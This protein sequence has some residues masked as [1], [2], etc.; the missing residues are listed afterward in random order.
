MR[1]GELLDRT[2][3]VLDE[4][5]LE[6]L[7]ERDPETG[8]RLA[9]VELAKIAYASGGL[10]VAGMLARPRG[11]GPHPSVIW[12]RGGHGASGVISARQAATQLAPIADRGYVVVASQYRGN[13][14]GEG[15]DEFG[16]AELADVLNLVPL[17]D[18][19]PDADPERIGMWG[20]SRGGLMTYLAMARTERLRAAVALS[21]VS[22]LADYLAHRPEMRQRVFDKLLPTDPAEREAAIARRSPVRWP[23]KL[24]KTTPLLVMH[25]SADWRVHAGQAL[26]MAAALQ[27]AMHP[28]RFVLFEGADHGLAEF[29]GEAQR[30][31]QEWLDRYLR[32]RLPWPSLEPHGL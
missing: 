20:W 2:P 29:S 1:D 4:A 9:R 16:G 24:C 12:N 30:F 18:A 3:I 25:G 17:L 5:T 8:R 14:G 31:A 11:P 10:R 23:E 22:D 26:A 32:D 19:M 21:A 6:R 15:T 28:F 7:A 27:A 13:A